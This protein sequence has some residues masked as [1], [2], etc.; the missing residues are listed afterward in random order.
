MLGTS[1]V[2]FYFDSE[3]E[4]TARANLKAVRQAKQSARLA[5]LDQP[6]QEEEEDTSSSY[7][8][9]E[10][11]IEMAENPPLPPPPRRTLGD[12]TTS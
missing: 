5:T 6:S 9:E 12:S 7:I 8:L 3:I 11:H 1:S 2:E 4:R 10:E